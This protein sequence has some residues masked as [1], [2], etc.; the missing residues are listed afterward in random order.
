MRVQKTDVAVIGGGAA[1]LMTAGAAAA[2]GLDVLLFEPNR[3]VGR[4]LGITGKGRCNVTNACPPGKVLENI[5]TNGSFLYSALSRFTPDDTMAFFESLGVE[6]KVERG[7]RVFP[8]SDRAADIVNALRRYCADSGAAVVRERV[9]GIETDC[10][11]VRAV[12][13]PSGRYECSSAVICTGGL[14][15]PLTGSTGDGYKLAKACGH[16]VIPQRPSLVPLSAA[17]DFCAQMQGLSL[18][19][20]SLTAFDSH[21][22]KLFSDLGEMLFTH[23]GISGPLAISASA[24]MRDYEHERYHVLIDLKPGLDE[25]KLDDRILRDFA[26]Y[27][28][29]EFAN[30]LGELLNRTMIPVVVRLS[31]IPG[32][33]K[34]NSI[35]RAQRRDLVR[36]IKNFRIDIAGPHSMDEAIITSGGICVKEIDPKTMESKL[37]HGLFFA[38]EVID[39]DAYTGGFNLQIAWSTAQA[40]ARSVR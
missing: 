6:L 24:H 4:K 40:A 28:N 23:F 27:S 32:D 30:S 25:K 29:R 10:A 19:N 3:C 11:R 37:V 33:E 18:R 34:V 1:G 17:Q 5:P 26:K 36:L 7:N 13:T 9:V 2:R 20:V 14:S 21:G 38:G 22:K 35:T 15:Y 8:C 39:A 16:T 31:G 12:A